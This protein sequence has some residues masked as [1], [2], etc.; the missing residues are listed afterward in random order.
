MNKNEIQYYWVIPRKDGNS[1]LCPLCDSE[2]KHCELGEFCSD[3]KCSYFDGRAA[4]DR[5]GY[6][7]FKDK[8]IS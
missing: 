6:E 3:K 4:L 7:K 1:S 2:L 5:A 8:I